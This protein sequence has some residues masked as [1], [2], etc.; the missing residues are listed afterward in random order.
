VSDDTHHVPDGPLP[1]KPAGSAAG[2][3]LTFGRYTTSGQLGAG[4][5]G[6]VYRAH[7]ELLGRDVAIK[8]LTANGELGVRERFLR[9]ARAIGAVHHPNI[10][11]VHDV[12]EQ[13]TTP[14]LVMEL[15]AGGSL[16]DH[17]KARGS[18][19]ADTVRELGIHIALA[20]AAAHAAGIVH[21]DVKPGN[22]LFSAPLWKLADFGIAHTPDSTLTMTGQF[23]GSPSYA[24]PE[25]L[26]SGQFSAASDVYSLG[27]TLYEAL[28]GT[29]PHGDHDMQS[30]IRK[31]EHDPTPLAMRVPS[32]PHRLAE[33]I[34]T[35]LAR[36]PAV[37]PSAEALA[38]RLAARDDV[39]APSTNIGSHA[40]APGSMGSHAPAPSSMGSHAPAPS[41]MGSHA[42]AP[43]AIGSHAPAPS[44][45]GSHAPAPSAMGSHA[46]A[47]SA[48]GLHAPA[49]SAI[50]SHAAPSAIGSHAPAPSA[51]G[52]HAPAP[53]ALGSHAP[54]S[55]M[56]G[57]HAPPVPSG[58]APTTPALN[59][60]SSA[61]RPDA[62]P[63]PPDASTGSRDHAPALLARVPGPG[64]SMKL[65][66]LGLLAIAVLAI[67]L[68][69]RSPDARSPGTSAGAVP[70]ALLPGMG[71]ASPQQAFDQNGNPLVDQDGNPIMG[72]PV[73]DE[74]GN[75][76]V[77]PNG[78]P[79]LADPSGRPI[80]VDQDGN[81]VDDETARRILEQ[82]ERDAR[83]A[84]DHPGKGKGRKKHHGE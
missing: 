23:L 64:P 25:S 53:S 60:L 42:P 46:A 33:A 84:F 74:H 39:A 19:S 52:S 16:R 36:D 70:A 65:I 63:G 20:L 13:D 75:P 72:S 80:V 61:A 3:A 34:M 47:P 57:T 26:R 40:P 41:A 37:R 31:L 27:A 59:A 7:D 67:V 8:S 49:S 71:G 28:A 58:L 48:L 43:S 73:V 62:A 79:V 56:V 29:P 76:I 10:L 4:G 77:D 6:T 69:L 22:I 66:A 55:S 14:Y 32:V 54:T 38:E 83:D 68:A 24:A 78:N 81:P 1:A 30:L 18:L 50:G 5:M 21:R 15:A 35:A 82:M 9:E 11:A 17:I 44:A 2:D 51:M 45:I 12:G